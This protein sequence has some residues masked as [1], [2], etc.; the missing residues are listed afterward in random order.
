MAPHRLSVAFLSLSLAACGAARTAPATQ[1]TLKAFDT[2]KSEPKAVEIS[3]GVLAA[4]G[5]EAAW[6]NAKEI[7]WTQLI[8]IDGALQDWGYHSWDRWN[9]RHQYK[10]LYADGNASVAM[11]ELYTETGTAYIEGP[12]GRVEQTKEDQR[13][14]IK[15]AKKRFDLDTYIMFLPYK[16]KDPGV[17]LK[18][19]EE[20]QEEGAPGDAPMKY[21]VI[22]ITF[23]EG[24]GPASGDTW[25]LS[26]DKETKIPNMVEHVS[27]GKPDNERG[28]FLLEDWK[29]VGGIKLAMRRV[30]LG[31]TKM[32]AAKVKPTVP[33]AWAKKVNMPPMEVPQRSEIVV[34]QD[35]KVSNEPDDDLYIPQVRAPN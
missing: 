1:S 6:N 14:I 3:D 23:D 33:P 21:D 17:K 24:V 29:D 25:Y 13:N 34:L 11:H 26:V 7:Q 20:R 27:A 15:E 10:R 2:S 19:S 35:V 28:G 18:F 4:L 12:K 32:D 9:A 22:Q 16:L 30:T 8:V 5:G 31:Y